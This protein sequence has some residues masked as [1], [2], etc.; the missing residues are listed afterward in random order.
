M[1]KYYL[2][3]G[4]KI[5]VDDSKPIG[6]GGE[7][8]VFKLAKNPNILVKVYNDRALMR[9][10]DIEPK[11]KA[12]V[13]KKPALLEYNG[14]TIIAWPSYV[15][16]DE[17]KKFVG[18]LMRRV[19]AKNQ[20]SH[21]ITP[22]LQ[23]K[24]FPNI[25]W[26]DRL[27]IAINLAKVMSFLHK[28]DT[29]IGDIN[30]SD[31]FV[32]PAFEIGV[33]DTD[34]FQVSSEQRL[35]HC[36]VFTPDYTPPEV[37]E[38]KKRTTQE[39]KRIPN[40]DNYGLAILIFQILMMGVHPF[41]AR[42]KGILGFDGNAI[43]YNMENEIFP[44]FTKNSNIIPPKNAMPFS[45][46]P[47]H[48]QDLFIRAFEKNTNVINRPTADEWVNGL[49]KVKDNI[50]KCKR[51]KA[52]YYPNHFQKCPICAKEQTKDYDY[53]LE[54]F[55]T[56]SK[57]YVKYETSDKPIIV[58]ENHSYD[59]TLVSK[60]YTLKNSK[61]LAIFFHPK[62]IEK[63]HLDQRIEVHVALKSY[64]K[65]KQYFLPPEDIIYDS[66]KTRVIGYVSP[67]REPLYKLQN[68]FK[69]NR[70]GKLKITEKTKWI[71][72]RN[73]A[74]M[75]S[76][77]EKYETHIEINQIF[78]DK[79]LNVFVPDVVL[80]GTPDQKF[81]SMSFQKEEYLPQ[82]YYLM[83]K[84]QAYQREIQAQIDLEKEKERKRLEAIRQKDLDLIKS[85]FE[86][87][88]EKKQKALEEKEAKVIELKPEKEVI[89]FEFEKSHDALIEKEPEEEK[90][91]VPLK[92]ES[93]DI[94]SK[95]SIRFTLAVIIF[96]ILND[97]HPFR[98]TY[99]LAHKN[100]SFFVENNYFIHKGFVPGAEIIE[101]SK[102]IETFPNYYQKTLKN[103]LYLK[104]PL[105]IHRPSPS[106]WHGVLSKMIFES[107]KCDTNEYHFYHQSMTK[108]PHCYT[109]EPKDHEQV[110]RFVRENK[111]GIIH[112]MIFANKILNYSTLA[113]ILLGVLYVVNRYSFS[114]L[115]Q[116]LSDIN[117]LDKI[118]TLKNFIRYDDI[119]GFFRNLFNGLKNL[120][121]S[122]FGG[123]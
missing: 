96:M 35:F 55:K 81:K 117:F 48:L 44:Y 68:F 119:I 99:K 12:M 104:D 49:R 36:K 67:A 62:M 6:S 24:K 85:P 121:D 109:K 38:A 28:N 70:L 69:N 107:K 43:N 59:E 94:N 93:F 16:Y 3:D 65:M 29:V 34:S 87:E 76:V 51:H 100:I 84:Y 4:S 47:K 22:G 110:R 53:L 18:Y 88:K 116:M 52:H 75:F 64:Q 15:I 71:V 33:V 37:I 21:V 82:E 2:E 26:Y 60:S 118:E 102:L 56:I 90:V 54:H 46:F 9:M 7:G 79:N 31:F 45:F 27:V 5:L 105:K 17:Q 39:V 112:H 80:M 74:S 32:Y 40:H 20:L 101:R 92:F 83:L 111:R 97:E 91:E 42:I 63:Y 30:T 95:Q 61:K 72:A 98:G 57:K 1:R 58:D 8:S 73:I 25:T 10:P 13:S 14:L 11:I 50:K 120:Y 78:V 86:K 122:I 77:L 108:C 114:N 66:G 123:A 89:D 103:A 106:E 19:Q 115:D 41:S 113:G 23:A